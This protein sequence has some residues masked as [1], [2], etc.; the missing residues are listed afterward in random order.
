MLSEHALMLGAV[1]DSD[2]T[3][4]FQNCRLAA[5]LQ[6]PDFWRV[7]VEDPER[8]QKNVTLLWKVR[9][10]RFWSFTLKDA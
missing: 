10:L 5:P 3:L 9:T 4:F 7:I 8:R 6:G 2:V 1:S